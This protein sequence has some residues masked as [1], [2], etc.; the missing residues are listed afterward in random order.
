MRNILKWLGL[1]L[2]S[3]I[4]IAAIVIGFLI[5]QSEPMP[6]HPFFANLPDEDF[7]IMAHQ[8]GDGEFPSNTL[9]A[10][11]QAAALG[12]DVL[13]IDVHS[14]AD[15]VLVVIHDATIDRTTNGSGRVNDLTFA[16]LQTF[17]AGYNWPTLAGHPLL[18][19]GEFPYRGDGLT[20]P[21]LE[22]VFIEFPDMPISIEIKQETPSIA[23]SLCD[24]IRQYER[25]SLTIVPSFRAE[26]MI[27]FR[28]IC[29]E[30]ASAAVESEVIQFFALSYLGLGAAW[31]PTTE[32]FMIPEYQGDLQVISQ[33]FIDQSHGRNVRIYPWTINSADQIQRMIDYGVDGIITDYPSLA[34][35]LAGRR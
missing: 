4:I 32:T 22:D 25:E 24:L 26:A 30:V 23:Q 17:D 29:P 35:E 6:E 27:E 2:T 15:D 10:L 14:S 33:R 20:I 21:S 1:V 19:T 28:D 5:W 12:V 11:Q 18:D 16:E 7:I 8:G 13:E 31:Q 3:I 34:L 9:F